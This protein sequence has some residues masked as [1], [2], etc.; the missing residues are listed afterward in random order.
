MLTLSELGIGPI[1]AGAIVSSDK[2]HNPFKALGRKIYLP[3]QGASVTALGGLQAQGVGEGEAKKTSGTASAVIVG[4]NKMQV[5]VVET[6]EF[7]KHAAAT[8]VPELI[9]NEFPKAIATQT[10][11]ITAGI[12]PV[13]AGWSNYANFGTAITTEVEVAAGEAASVDLDDAFAGVASGVVTGMVLSTSM[14]A[15]LK[16]QRN[17]KTGTRVFEVDGDTTTGFLDGVRYETFVS[18]TA[19]GYVGNFDNFVY[20]EE[21]FTNPITGDAFIIHTAGNETDF[22]GVVHNLNA[23]N[24]VALRYEQIVGSGIAD[25][26]SFVKIVPAA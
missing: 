10:A 25:V 15:Y 22:N 13:P 26:D 11:L 21:A 6:Y 24:K 17:S 23:E 16:R 1:D 8:N 2:G 20:G 12:A 19:V 7:F 4:A 3:L 18:A 9:F 14:L 5:S